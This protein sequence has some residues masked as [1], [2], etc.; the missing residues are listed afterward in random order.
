MFSDGQFYVAS[1]SPTGILKPRVSEMLSNY[2]SSITSGNYSLDVIIV[3]D[4]C[5]ETLTLHRAKQ[6]HILIIL[7][8]QGV[9]P[10]V[11]KP[12]AFKLELYFLASHAA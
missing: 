3:I 12:C 8:Q 4:R 6:A 1:F 11:R 9:P 5:G 2:S 7:L 10:D